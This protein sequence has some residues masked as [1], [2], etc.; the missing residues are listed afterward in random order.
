[1]KKTVA[2]AGLVLQFCLPT[3]QAQTNAFA[4]TLTGQLSRDRDKSVISTAQLLGSA[5]H[6]LVLVVDRSNDFIAL[7]EVDP[8][9]STT[10]REI[11]GSWG[12]AIL[13]TG[14]FSADLTVADPATAVTFAAAVPAFNGVLQ[15]DGVIAAGHTPKLTATLVGYWKDARFAPRDEPAALFRGRLRSV[16]AVAVPADY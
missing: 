11:M 12:A 15:I 3:A 7:L 8:A 4:V 13:G 5:S 10:V 2:L 16:G 6:A 14:R 1:M 9:T